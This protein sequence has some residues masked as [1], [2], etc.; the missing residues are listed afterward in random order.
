MW[1]EADRHGLANSILVEYENTM[2]GWVVDTSRSFGLI[3]N[4]DA[5]VAATN[6]SYS[7]RWSAALLTRARS[8]RPVSTAAV[9]ASVSEM[10]GMT[11]ASR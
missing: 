4:I 11:K 3:Y 8:S 7:A 2:D 6:L 5:M 10:M 1:S 9:A